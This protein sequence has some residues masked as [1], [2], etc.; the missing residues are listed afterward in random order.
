[1]SKKHPKPT[2]ANQRPKSTS[3]LAQPTASTSLT[4]LTAFSPEPSDFFAQLSLAVDAHTLRI[5]DVVT[6]RCTARWAASEAREKVTCI[7]WVEVPS[8]AKVADSKR[9]KKRRKSSSAAEKEPVD[10]SD[11]TPRVQ[12]VALG[13]SNGTIALVHP[14]QSTV[15]KTLSH[16]SSTKPVTSLSAPLLSSDMIWSCSS[17]GV[18]RVWTLPD[19]V[20]NGGRLLARMEGVGAGWDR[21]SVRYLDST[22]HDGRRDVS[23]NGTHDSTKAQLLVAQHAIR[24]LEVTL[25]FSVRSRGPAGGE[26]DLA[27]VDLNP[28]VAASFTGH[29]TEVTTLV[30]L[31]ST[32][33][34][35][36]PDGSLTNGVSKLA[37]EPSFLS[38][39]S[40]DR[41][42][43]LWSFPKPTS[44]P[45][46]STK[47]PE[48]TLVASLALDDPVHKAF[49]VGP[50][51]AALSTSGIL[52]VA[53]VNQ[54]PEKKSKSPVVA[55]KPTSEV[56][57]KSGG[58]PL[59]DVLLIAAE[60]GGANAI[61]AARGSVKPIFETVVSSQDVTGCGFLGYSTSL[62][63]VGR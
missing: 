60:E 24:L 13:L 7:E 39:A 46:K 34:Q 21:I 55:L 45:S 10:P 59:I 30:W 43:N 5:Y 6:G 18:V 62:P 8:Q 48:G 16:P 28:R 49:A 2:P 20:G 58:E 3:E 35:D 32:S 14:N 51:V 31:P 38:C 52:A 63:V 50:F 37:S 29:A 22:H 44:S 11:A 23:M 12:L 26:E 53:R 25:P 54:K 47:A 61:K 56:A 15:V 42:V 4:A 1:M 40:S 36:P 9:G 27:V 57:V 19:L 17:D 33:S 41:F